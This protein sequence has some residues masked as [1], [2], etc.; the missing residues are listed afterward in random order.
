MSFKLFDLITHEP[1]PE[2]LGAFIVSFCFQEDLGNSEDFI[3]GSNRVRQRQCPGFHLKVHILKLQCYRFTLRKKLEKKRH[4][5]RQFCLLRNSFLSI[6][7][8]DN[9]LWRIIHK[10]KNRTVKSIWLICHNTLCE[11]LAIKRFHCNV[12]SSHGDICKVDRSPCC[13]PNG[14]PF[15][16]AMMVTQ[17]GGWWWCQAIQFFFLLIHSGMYSFRSLCVIWLGVTGMLSISIRISPM[18]ASLF[19]VITQRHPVQI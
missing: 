17:A 6:S 4:L 9:I 15:P 1:Q 7:M 11:K 2:W 12:I 13:L 16:P 18:H 10:R 5:L 19:L 14:P 3:H 8:K